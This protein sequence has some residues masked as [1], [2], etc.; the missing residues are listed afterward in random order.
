MPRGLAWVP[1]GCRQDAA[2][3][4]CGAPRGLRRGLPRGRREGLPRG[5]PRGLPNK[6]GN[7]I[8]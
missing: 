4:R 1:R 5:M 3:R 8:A 2:G 7:L 6:G